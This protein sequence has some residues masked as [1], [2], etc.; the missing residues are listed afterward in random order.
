MSVKHAFSSESDR[1]RR[2]MLRQI[3]ELPISALCVCAPYRRGSNDEPAR[4]R[5]IEALVG[6]LD[7]AV[8]VL[9]L[10]T[11]GQERD[12]ADNRAIRA[13]LLAAG[14]ADKV[15]YSHRGSRDEALLALPDAIGWSIGAGG[16]FSK[17]ASQRTQQ[18]FLRRELS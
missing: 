17:L 4:R 16:A 15:V 14:R 10:D 18:I 2:R 11:R 13:C 6:S 12:R 8:A 1:E 9:V 3:L 5:C 7:D